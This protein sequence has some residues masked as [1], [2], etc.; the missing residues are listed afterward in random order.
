[1]LMYLMLHVNVKYCLELISFLCVF[2]L[3]YT[4]FYLGMF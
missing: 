2:D 4:L 3:V 1:L